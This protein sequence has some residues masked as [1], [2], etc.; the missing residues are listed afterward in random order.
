[1]WFSSGYA[2]Y[3]GD[4]QSQTFAD[5]ADAEISRYVVIRDLASADK[6]LFGARAS[7]K[8]A[9]YVERI[10]LGKVVVSGKSS[11][12]ELY[13]GADQALPTGRSALL[14]LDLGLDDLD[15]VWWSNLDGDRLP[16]EGP[17]K[18]L[19]TRRRQREGRVRRVRRL[20][21]EA[22]SV[23]RKLW[24]AY[25]WDRHRGALGGQFGSWV[26]GFSNVR[27][28]KCDQAGKSMS[29]FNLSEP[30]RDR[31][32]QQC[33]GPIPRELLLPPQNSLFIP[34]KLCVRGYEQGIS[35]EQRV[36]FGLLHSVADCSACIRRCATT[37]TAQHVDRVALGEVAVNGETPILE[38]LTCEDHALLIR[39]HPILVLDLSLDVPN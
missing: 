36:P 27:T 38:L 21:K 33:S 25:M 10:A 35:F 12:L 37:E 19:Q 31:L 18:K 11:I 34:R 17:Y 3:I 2:V 7:I 26:V 22:S 32:I 5:R 8:T 39:R 15:R 29:R 16:G 13:S 14:G 23:H 30:R 24:D 9:Q 1:M 20:G 4:G 28:T 6:L